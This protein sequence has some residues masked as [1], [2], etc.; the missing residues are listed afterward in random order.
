MDDSEI[1]NSIHHI[2][3]KPKWAIVALVKKNKLD[4]LQIRNRAIVS[5]LKPYAN[6]YNITILMFSEKAFTSNVI[7]QWSKTFKSVGIVKYINT[8]KN[9]Y[10][11]TERYGYKYMCKFFSIDL[12]DYL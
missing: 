8:A 9:G 1:S 4:D 2:Q 6:K 11:L 10:G 7:N 12:Y 3:G 5:M